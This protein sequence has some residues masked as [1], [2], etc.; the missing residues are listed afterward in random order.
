MIELGSFVVG[1]VPPPI[2]YSYL[3]AAG[4]PIN[5]TGYTATFSIVKGDGTDL[6]RTADLS[7]GPNGEVTYIWVA[8]DMDTAGV[9]R[10]EFKAT[11][12][13]NTFYSERFVGYVRAALYV[14]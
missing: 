6:S 12:G 4:D 2:E 14:A 3:D 10:C 13:T 7:D 5:L 9:L 1:E 8:A 11:N